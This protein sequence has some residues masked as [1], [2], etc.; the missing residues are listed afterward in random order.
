MSNQDTEQIN[1]DNNNKDKEKE[2]KNK[3][4]KRLVVVIIVLI[5]LW[6]FTVVLGVG[7]F[8]R[9]ND[10]DDKPDHD[11]DFDQGMEKILEI[12]PAERKAYLDKL[13][14]DGQ[15]NIN[16]SPSA[17][18][19]GK[20][21]T[22]I[23]VRNIDNN[24]DNIIFKLYDEDGN[25]IYTSKEI[26]RGYECTSIT[27]DKALPKGEHNGKISIGYVSGGNVTS[28]FPITLISE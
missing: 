20:K 27:L 25:E 6:L 13:V 7:L 28:M 18:F 24:K 10:G 23:C 3:G 16:Y 9:N 11:S 26:Q 15:I 14:A 1:T 17:K 21:S 22:A 5:I 2:N 4:K 19:E 12:D 8:L